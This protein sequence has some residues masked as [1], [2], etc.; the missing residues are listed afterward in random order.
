M[1]VFE[2]IQRATSR[3]EPIHSSFLADMLRDS[4]SADRGL[5]E[6]VWSLVAPEQWSPP[7]S[8]HIE[9]EDV[10][11]NGR[12]D[13]VIRDDERRRIIGIEVKTVDASAEQG[14]LQRY[15]DGLREKYP[16]NEVALA[17]LT[18]FN[19]ARAGDAADSLASVREFDRFSSSHELARH[20]SWLDIAA[21]ERQADAIWQQ[22][23]DYVQRHISAPAKLERRLQTD[24]RFSD[25]FGEEAS[26]AFWEALIDAGAEPA[27]DI[28]DLAMLEN[29][30]AFAAAFEHLF[31]SSNVDATTSRESTFSTE[32][33]EAFLTS[34]F[35]EFH[36]K[37]FTFG[38]RLSFVWLDGKRDYGLR[39]AHP[40]HGTGVSVATSR[41]PRFLRIGQAR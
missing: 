11:S 9:T 7:A 36:R 1:N 23:Q 40:Q 31:R 10:L 35:G 17:Y 15:L 24:R 37:L 38:D 30:R 14:Q 39:V 5:F 25:F 21:Y 27:G 41:T 18:P 3:T 22:H 28:V 19:R 34:E 13:I 32:L 8:A 20:V 12:V 16:I 2:S 33:Q 4:L 26:D 6:Y 29:P